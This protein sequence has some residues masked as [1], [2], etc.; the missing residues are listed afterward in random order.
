MHHCMSMCFMHMHCECICL[1]I[2]CKCRIW[3]A[4]RNIH[5]PTH[6]SFLCTSSSSFFL[7][8]SSCLRVSFSRPRQCVRGAGHVSQHTI[9]STRMRNVHAYEP[10]LETT[11][12][13]ACTRSTY[14]APPGH[15][16]V[17]RSPYLQRSQQQ[18]PQQQRQ[19]ASHMTCD[20][21]WLLHTTCLYVIGVLIMWV[22][23]PEALYSM[24]G[25]TLFSQQ[26]RK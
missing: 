18:H 24:H 26:C 5:T 12:V 3:N 23:Y 9:L 4:H 10:V 22:E 13:H 14:H 1:S 2:V 7:L 6:T 21:R 16:V 8:A 15:D 11:Y 17:R 20:V 19:P 25:C